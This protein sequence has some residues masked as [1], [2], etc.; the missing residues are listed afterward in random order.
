[1]NIRQLIADLTYKLSNNKSKK[2]T[3]FALKNVRFET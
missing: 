1:L 3:I 2:C